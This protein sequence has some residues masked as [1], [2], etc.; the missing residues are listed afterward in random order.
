MCSATQVWKLVFVKL[1]CRLYALTFV[2]HLSILTRCNDW[3]VASCTY[4]TRISL[5]SLNPTTMMLHHCKL[6]HWCFRGVLRY[7]SLRE[8]GSWRAK[9]VNAM[10]LLPTL[11]AVPEL[12][13]ILR[14]DGVRKI[15]IIH[16]STARVSSRSDNIWALLCIDT[17]P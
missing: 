2:K 15:G 4:V 8:L 16:R 9:N 1:D 10:L 5:K 12:V 13:F 14:A 17:L 6:G 3:R 11:V 7:K